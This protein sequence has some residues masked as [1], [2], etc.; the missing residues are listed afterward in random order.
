MRFKIPDNGVF[1][2]E[3]VTLFQRRL[4]KLEISKTHKLLKDLETEV[5]KHRLLVQDKIPMVLWGPLVSVLHF[6]H[7][8]EGLKLDD[9]HK[10][11][12]LRLSEHFDRP[13]KDYYDNFKILDSDITLPNYVL[14][15]LAMG[16]KASN[17][18][19][20]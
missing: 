12:L 2:D 9:T 4:L 7:I 18:G 17:V 3:A 10:N 15:C 19:P 5:A 20:F 16:P 13:I 1:K 6:D 14:N 8:T 11:K